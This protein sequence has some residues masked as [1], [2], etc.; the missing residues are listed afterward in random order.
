MTTVIAGLLGRGSGLYQFVTYLNEISLLL[1]IVISL[2]QAILKEVNRTYVLFSTAVLIISFYSFFSE[3]RLVLFAFF[4]AFGTIQTL[5]RKVLFRVLF[6]A[7]VFGNIIF[8]WQGIKPL[9]RAY[10]TG[11][12][13]LAGGLQSQAVNRS[14]TEALGKF[15]ELSQAFYAGEL[16]AQIENFEV[17][18]EELLYATLRRLGY[19]EFMALTI[20][21]VPSRLAH[22]KGELLVSNLS[23]AL[24]PRILNPNK[25]VKDDGAKVEKYTQFMVADS[26][27]FSL[28]HYV[29]YYIDFGRWGT[30]FMLILYGI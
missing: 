16:G 15:F 19:L 22:E 24:I 20:N 30:L 27:S 2:R 12:E 9:Y 25:G 13:T 23:F 6:F 26:A 17:D 5:T 3:W 10:L 18:N 1:F 29:E 8:L 11:Q 28:G 14:R 4:I 7:V 21:N